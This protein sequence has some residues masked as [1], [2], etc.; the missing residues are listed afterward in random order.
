MKDNVRMKE[1]KIGKF[2]IVR[3]TI[4]YKMQN[5]KP[6]SRVI[7]DRNNCDIY[8]VSNVETPSFLHT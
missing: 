3:I 1:A 8:Q 4:L 2:I 6:R 7:I 5:F